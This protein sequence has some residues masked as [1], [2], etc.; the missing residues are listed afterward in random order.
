M[1][2]A[3]LFPYWLKCVDCDAD[4]DDGGEFFF[5]STNFAI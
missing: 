2:L 1:I 5:L 3:K 4:D